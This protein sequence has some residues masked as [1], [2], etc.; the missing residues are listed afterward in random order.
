MKPIS[1]NRP[2]F[3]AVF[4]F[5][6]GACLIAASSCVTGCN[7][8]SYENGGTKVSCRR[9]FWNTESYAVEFST[10]GTAKLE[11][12]KSGV[13]AKAITDIITA[14]ATAAGAAIK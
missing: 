10:N 2:F 14:T 9:A 5:A 11:V 3:A 13:D 7:T 6:L 4:P 8:I 12:N 1:Q